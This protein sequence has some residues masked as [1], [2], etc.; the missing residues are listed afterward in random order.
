MPTTVAGATRIVLRPIGSPLPLGLLALVPAGLLF[1]LQQLGALQ[2]ED[3]MTIAVV[4]LAFVVPLQFVAGVLSFLARDAI[5]GTALTL[6]AGAWLTS[7]LGLLLSPPGTTSDA[8]GVFLLC[9]AAAFLVIVAG[10][11][12]GKFGPALVIV[13]GSVRFTLAA[14]AELTND[15]A[16]RH[17]GGVAGC[18]LVA[19]AL[20]SALATEIEDVHGEVKLPL[21]RRGMARH[22]LESS[23]EKQLDRIEHAAGV[24]QQL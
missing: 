15:D 6:Y 13:V 14:L 16:V 2:S 17:A 23:F 24:R 3:N 18:L 12:F 21:G 22:A 7:A 10:A 1:S 9:V 4:V 11:S 19:C 8:Q 20:Y 5:A